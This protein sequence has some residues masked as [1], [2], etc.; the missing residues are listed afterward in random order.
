[1]AILPSDNKIYAPA[2][3]VVEMVADYEACGYAAH[4]AGNGILLHVGIDTVQL[5]GK[6]FSVH[7]ETGQEVKR[8]TA[9]WM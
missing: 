9:S 2:D 5:G 6:Y 3:A 8:A 7:V 1:M 4:E